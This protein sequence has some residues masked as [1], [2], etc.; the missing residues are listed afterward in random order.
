MAEGIL[1]VR[2]HALG[3]TDL[4]VSSTGIHAHE[5]QPATSHAVRVCE[6]H[7][8]DISRHRSH[9]VKPREI[10]A[11]ELVLAMECVQIEFLTLFFPALTEKIHLL[12]SWPLPDSN[13]SNI[14]DPVGGS[15]NDYVKTYKLISSHIDRI[16]PS[17]IEML[18]KKE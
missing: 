6:D 16:I 1:R 8:I 12:G 14:S 13:K 3:R 4:F 15:F 17:L 10:S 9:P 5:D 11:S 18:D 7:G 2:W